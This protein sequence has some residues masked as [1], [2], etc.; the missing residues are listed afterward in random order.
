MGYRQAVQSAIRAHDN[1]AFVLESSTPSDELYVGSQLSLLIGRATVTR[2]TTILPAEALTEDAYFYDSYPG[3]VPN[4]RSLNA[5]NA[6][7]SREANIGAVTALV[8]L[9][10]WRRRKRPARKSSD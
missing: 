1:R 3:E 2:M 4:Q 6:F 5:H 7:R 10:M 9:G 8:L